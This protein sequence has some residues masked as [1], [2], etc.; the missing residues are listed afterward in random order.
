MGCVIVNPPGAK[1]P[2]PLFLYGMSTS[3][4]G[5]LLVTENQRGTAAPKGASMLPQA[6][7]LPR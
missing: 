5:H 7:S 1:Q 2:E 3:W 4:D 6:R